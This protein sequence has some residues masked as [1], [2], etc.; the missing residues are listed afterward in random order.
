MEMK[1]RAGESIEEKIVAFL[2]ERQWQVTCAESCT[3]GMVSSRLVNV[4]GV[5]DVF[6]ESY[7]TYSNPSKYK[8][9]GVTLNS[10][11]DFGAVSRQV[12]QEMAVGAAREAGAQA[13]VAVTGIAGPDGGTEE[14]PVGLV[15]IGCCIDKRTYVT[16]NHFSG[17]R[18]EIREQA[19]QAA[20]EML[21]RCLKG[22]KDC[23]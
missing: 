7:V 10:L 23:P 4:A 17:N 5:S 8:L 1:E 12:A 3:G 19:T 13:S 18:T 15:Y 2:K 21:Y 20:L 14:K 9:L 22:A 6:K 16:E 11:E